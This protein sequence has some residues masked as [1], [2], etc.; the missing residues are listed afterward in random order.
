VEKVLFFAGLHAMRTDQRGRTAMQLS[1]P[2][3]AWIAWSSWDH[4]LEWDLLQRTEAGFASWFRIGCTAAW[5]ASEAGQDG[6]SKGQ[7]RNYF[8]SWCSWANF[9]ASPNSL[10]AWSMWFMAAAR[11]PPQLPPACSRSFRAPW[12]ARLADSTS[13]GTSRCGALGKKVRGG[14]HDHQRKDY[15]GSNFHG[16]SSGYKRRIDEPESLRHCLRAWQSRFLLSLR[17]DSQGHWHW[18]FCNVSRDQDAW[19]RRWGWR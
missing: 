6:T 1:R 12:S 11:C 19:T 9:S 17:C 3:L 4:G 18:K 10:R 15:E 5:A 13:A 8:I 7:N 2:S 16:S 14:A